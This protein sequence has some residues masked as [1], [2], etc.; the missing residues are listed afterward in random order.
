M[1]PPPLVNQEGNPAPLELRGLKLCLQN[2]GQSLHFLQF[3]QPE[4]ASIFC[5]DD[6]NGVKLLDTFHCPDIE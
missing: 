5:S 4:T 6:D 1:S 3:N 2:H